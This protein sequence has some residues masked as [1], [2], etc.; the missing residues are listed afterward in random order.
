MVTDRARTLF[1]REVAP[2][3]DD[4][5]SLARWLTGSR[6]D[7]QDVVQDACMRALGGVEARHGERP[8][9][10]LLAIVR[11]C[12]FTWLGK[13]RPKDLVFTDDVQGAEAGSAVAREARAGAPD[14]ETALIAKAD[15][16]RLEAAIMGLP[17]RHRE[18]IVL[19]E[20]NGLSY[21]AI[22]EAVGAPVGTVMS[23]LA[24]ARRILTEKLTGDP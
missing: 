22:A 4:A 24:R 3:L 1:M 8:R 2:H 10:W 7:A 6:A 18:V 21:R 17:P 19:R 5:Y 15:A 12:A 14:A 20:L 13:N 23:R 9:A 16:A 11:N